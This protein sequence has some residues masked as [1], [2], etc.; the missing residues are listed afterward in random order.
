MKG[1]G[2]ET[3][4]PTQTDYSPT[5]DSAESPTVYESPTGDSSLRREQEQLEL[6]GA[7]AIAREIEELERARYDRRV[8]NAESEK[9]RLTL[10]YEFRMSLLDKELEA[11]KGTEEQKAEFSRL[12]AERKFEASGQLMDDLGQTGAE[13]DDMLKDMAESGVAKLE[14]A[15]VSLAQ[16]GKMSFSGMITAMLSD[17]SRLAASKAFSSVLNH[18]I[19]VK[20]ETTTTTTGSARGNV[21]SRHTIFPL[22]NG[23]GI[24]GESGSEGILPLK[25]NRNGDLGVVVSGGQG[26]QNSFNN[27]INIQ[28]G[29]TPQENPML[30]KQIQNA[31]RQQMETSARGVIGQQQRGYV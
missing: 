25:R 11:F 12:I 31:V 18:I 24:A 15:F 1:Y 22:A 29:G 14:N 7:R 17:L 8:A 5:G 27:T 10:D 2:A 20:A 13:S 23:M 30:I 6:A 19:P 26:G 16:T 28:Y 3:R 4:T 9:Q 21:I